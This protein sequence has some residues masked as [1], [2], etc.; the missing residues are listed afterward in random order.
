[1]KEAPPKSLVVFVAR[2]LALGPS[3]VASEDTESR[4]SAPA[5]GLLSSKSDMLCGLVAIG[6]SRAAAVCGESLEAG[7][8]GCR[9][10]QVVAGGARG[11]V[12]VGVSER[13]VKPRLVN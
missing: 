7:S 11:G 9:R 4:R 6:L 13:A 1:M 8:R 2:K 12:W 5:N 3:S 10:V